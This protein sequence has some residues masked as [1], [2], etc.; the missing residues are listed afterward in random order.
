PLAHRGEAGAL[1][2]L[3]SV[4]P[5]ALAKLARRTTLRLHAW[6][7]IQIALGLFVPFLLLP[8]SS[9]GVEDNY[10]YELARLWPSS[11]SCGGTAAWAF[12]FGCISMGPT[13]RPSPSSVAI[14]LPT[15]ALLGFIVSG[16]QV[17]SSI[18]NAQTFA[19]VK[20]VAHW[21][22]GCVRGARTLPLD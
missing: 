16:R 17:A 19:E 14:A 9:I 10:L 3:L 7:L 8:Q 11:W 5:R 2:P 15:C 22:K 21:P 12:T 18:A 20:T 4:P 13:A 1:Y 6:E